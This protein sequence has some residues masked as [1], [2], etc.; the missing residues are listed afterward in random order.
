M[1]RI[2]KG[3]Q[4]LTNAAI[5]NALVPRPLLVAHDLAT[6]ERLKALLHSATPLAISALGLVL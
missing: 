4:S 2:E 1:N 3:L 5:I 6:G